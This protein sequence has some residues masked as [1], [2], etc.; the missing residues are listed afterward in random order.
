[1][2]E[3][4]DSD[5]KELVEKEYLTMKM[6]EQYMSLLALPC[7]GQGNVHSPASP[8]AP[9]AHSGSSKGEAHFLFKPHIHLDFACVFELQDE[10]GAHNNEREEQEVEESDTPQLSED[11]DDETEE[12]RA[13][14]ERGERDEERRQTELQQA[15]AEEV[16]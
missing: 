13:A 12:D 1:L 6:N 7:S 3:L 9:I 15:A 14:R 16:I 5:I 11:S 4:T 8:K 2:L 10:S